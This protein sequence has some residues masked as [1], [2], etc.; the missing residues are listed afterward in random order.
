[1]TYNHRKNIPRS[2]YQS[3]PEPPLKKLVIPLDK[4]EKPLPNPE[5]AEKSKL[6]GFGRRRSSSVVSPPN[7]K[8]PLVAALS[9]STQKNSPPTS[10]QVSTPSTPSTP[11]YLSPRKLKS[12]KRTPKTSSVPAGLGMRDDQ[13]LVSKKGKD[14]AELRA[15][16]MRRAASTPCAIPLSKG[17]SRP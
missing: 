5:I 11:S 17:T 12:F 1:M 14:A 16:H 2:N 13:Q 8:N 4:E 7:H 6:W 3:L 10:P 15:N 9:R